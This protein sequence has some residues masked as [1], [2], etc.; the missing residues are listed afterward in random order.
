MRMNVTENRDGSTTLSWRLPTSI[1]TDYEAMREETGGGT[2]D[3]AE[4]FL[5]V[6]L[7][8]RRQLAT[9]GC[10]RTRCRPYRTPSCR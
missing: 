8:D 5:K 6:L 1:L 2:Y 10:H 4:S 9:T 7:F 3:T